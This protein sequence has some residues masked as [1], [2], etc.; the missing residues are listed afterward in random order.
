MCD[1][2]IYDG[3]SPEWAAV[4]DGIQP[5]PAGLSIKERQALINK[6]R[7]S[8]SAETMRSLGP[9]VSTRDYKITTKDG[10]IIPARS[11]RSVQAARGAATETPLPLYIHLHGGGYFF[12]TLDS[13]DAICSRIALGSGAVVLNVDY[14]HAP[15]FKY[16]CAWDDGA[17]ALEW[18][19]ANTAE[20]G[21]DPAKVVVGGISA[22]AQIAASLTLGQRLGMLAASAP[23]PPIAGQVLMIPCL[24]HTDCY[25]PQLGR[26][27]DPSRSSRVVNETAPILPMSAVRFFTDVLGVE[28]PR[29][30]DLRLNPGN[31]TVEQVKGLPPT[32][33]G[34]AGRD[35][36]RDEGLLYANLLTEAGYG[37]FLTTSYLKTNSRSSANLLGCAA[38]LLLMCI[39]SRAYRTALGGT[40]ISCRRLGFGT[41][42]WRMVSFGPC[43][44]PV[45]RK[46]YKS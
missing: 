35:P 29:P 9:Q 42:S 3:V 8:I 32:V 25:G 38:V 37:L 1:F 40:G 14:R 44:D 17:A 21:I 39:Y 16:P 10:S 43:P 34:I 12:G 15:D 33:L 41:M 2:T 19:H 23:L 46:V 27:R 26:L 4:E 36:L 28:D 13:E 11:Y 22:G 18:A 20:L 6:E 24:V 7:E 5:R 31:A 30:E 45:H